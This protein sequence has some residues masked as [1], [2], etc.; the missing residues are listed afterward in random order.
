MSEIKK[1]IEVLKDRIFKAEK[2]L[3]ENSD[4]EDFIKDRTRRVMFA[5]SEA[6]QSLQ[7][8]D[9]ALEGLGEK[10]I[11]EI[12]TSFSNHV[13]RH[14]AKGYNQCHDI[15]SK[16]IAKDKK[17]IA[18]LK[19]KN[20][21]SNTVILQAYI[22]GYERG[23]DDTVESCYGNIEVKADD[24]L[25]DLEEEDCVS[26]CQEVAILKKEI[27]D[28]QDKNSSCAEAMEIGKEKIADLK[29][30]TLEMSY[31]AIAQGEK[32]TELQEKIKELKDKLQESEE[33]RL[34][35]EKSLESVI[36]KYTKLVKT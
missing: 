11:V 36:R 27:A 19:A 28:L 26:H 20:K 17:T 24:Y 7:A 5:L 34:S 16:I 29:E 21:V 33:G 14:R 23:H 31:D 35:L 9:Q 13:E 2:Y 22:C 3:E 4:L 6:I 8:Q 32:I 1:S 12:A 18:D 25:E 15:A 10:K 30:K